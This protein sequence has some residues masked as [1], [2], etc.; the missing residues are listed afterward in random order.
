[1]LKK[2]VKKIFDLSVKK[3]FEEKLASN[4][5]QEEW[6]KFLKEFRVSGNPIYKISM[7][8]SKAFTKKE[9]LNK[10]GSLKTDI[11]E[12]RAMGK[13]RGQ[14]FRR[15][16]GNKGQIIYNNGKKWAVE[17]IYPFDSI[18]N[19]LKEFK[20]KY[21]KILFWNMKMPLYLRNAIEIGK[22]NKQ[23]QLKSGLYCLTQ[24]RTDGRATIVNCDNVEYIVP[25]NKLLEEG[26][27]Y[28]QRS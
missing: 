12:Y 6:E 3:A 25:I 15:E 26:K 16:K 22:N 17:Q 4:P 18:V 1:M 19:K 28:K 7:I 8:D 21:G 27:A 10:D 11:G 20:A 2:N 23:I 9:A 14:Y 24:L 13:V 5:T